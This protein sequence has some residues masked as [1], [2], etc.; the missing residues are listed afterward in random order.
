[1]SYELVVFSCC[2][3]GCFEISVKTSGYGSMG[4]NK[5][6]VPEKVCLKMYIFL[7]I[8]L[9]RHLSTYRCVLTMK[10]HN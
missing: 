4:Q 6:K 1:M 9:H 5:K 2:I 3:S 10:I 7:S 8:C